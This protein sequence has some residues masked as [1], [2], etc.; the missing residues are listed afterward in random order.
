MKPPAF[1][2]KL[3]QR[4]TSRSHAHLLGGRVRISTVGL[5]VAFVALFWVYDTYSVPLQTPPAPTNQVVPPGFVPDPEY[6]W[7]PRT[8]VAPRSPEPTTTTTTTTP[9]TTTTTPS[10]E[11]TGPDDTTSPTSPTSPESPEP[12]AGPTTTVIDPDGPGPSDAQTFTQLPPETPTP[13]PTTQPA[14]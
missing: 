9:A 10:E 2:T 13:A 3:V 6:T 5:I 11:T 8:N 12:P 4:S 14:P 1:L 7:V